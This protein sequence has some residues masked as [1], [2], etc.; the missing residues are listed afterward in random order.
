[1]PQTILE[2]T[3]DLMM[4]Q[5]QT[6]ALSPDDMRKVLHQ[7]YSS[8]MTLKALEDGNG[9]VVA[10]TP[11]TPPA[12]VDWR[13]SITKHTVTCLECG[14]AFKQLSVRHLRHHALDARSYRAKYG[15]PRTQALAAKDTIVMRKQ[16]VQETRPWEQAPMYRK[17]QTRKATVVKAGQR[18]KIRTARA[19]A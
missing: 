3:K 5:I 8:L 7:T 1:M 14:Q 13:K 4:T 9:S 6:K 17:A 2:M 18:G 11:E 10:E 15:I 16:I 12:P 19:K